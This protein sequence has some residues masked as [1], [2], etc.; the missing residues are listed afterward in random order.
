MAKYNEVVEYHKKGMEK[1][2]KIS[3][4]QHE[5][6]K[7]AYKDAEKAIKEVLDAFTKGLEEKVRDWTKEDYDQFIKTA[8]HDNRLDGRSILVISTAYARTHEDDKER[9]HNNTCK[10]A[11][12]EMAMKVM[13]DLLEMT[14]LR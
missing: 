9:V 12:L 2:E 14:G 11:M 10:K 5:I 13:D 6:L 4:E 8:K 7:Q 1:C 3:G